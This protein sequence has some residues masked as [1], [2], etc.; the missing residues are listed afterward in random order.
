MRIRCN[1]RIF[2]VLTINIYYNLLQ[3][4]CMSSCGLSIIWTQANWY[5]LIIPWAMANTLMVEIG[6]NQPSIILDPH[7]HRQVVS[8]ILVFLIHFKVIRSYP[9]IRHAVTVKYISRN[10]HNFPKYIG[11]FSTIFHNFP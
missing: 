9:K 6:S 10:V 2:L 7:L 3:N 11:Y 5:P 8:G 4:D 1:S